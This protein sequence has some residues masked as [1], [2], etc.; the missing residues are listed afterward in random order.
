MDHL[1]LAI[2]NW[3]DLRLWY[4]PPLII[5]VSLVY[6]ASRYE[7]PERIIRRAARMA[8]MVTIAMAGAMLLIEFLSRGL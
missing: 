4:L 1:L 3:R 7:A 2:E 5:V 6:S 8:F